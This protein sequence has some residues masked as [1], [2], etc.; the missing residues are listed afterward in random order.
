MD[1]KTD[2]DPYPI[3]NFHIIRPIIGVYPL[4]KKQKK[5]NEKP[6]LSE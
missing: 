4:A 1:A 3:K 6:L 5:L 2:K